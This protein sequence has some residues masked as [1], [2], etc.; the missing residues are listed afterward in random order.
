M[1]SIPFKKKYTEHKDLQ[2]LNWIF[3]STPDN[4]ISTNIKRWATFLIS[5]T[6]F[7]DLFKWIPAW[8]T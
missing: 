4:H 7:C 2:D 3:N 5:S 8:T 1:I 6:H